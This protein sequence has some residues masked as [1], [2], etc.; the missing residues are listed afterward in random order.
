MIMENIQFGCHVRHPDD[1][2][3]RLIAPL[4]ATRIERQRCAEIALHPIAPGEL[5]PV[6]IYPSDMA[7]YQA[8]FRNAC[9]IIHKRIIHVPQP[10]TMG[11]G[12]P[13]ND[14]S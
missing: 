5:L 11:Y 8:G 1:S 9:E 13:V 3:K 12:E 6:A 2:S 10:G 7:A 4:W 14:Q